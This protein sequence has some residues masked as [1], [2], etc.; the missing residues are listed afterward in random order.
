MA[1]SYEHRDDEL[2]GLTTEHFLFGS[3]GHR[4]LKED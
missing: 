2:S 3:T 1:G 4:Q